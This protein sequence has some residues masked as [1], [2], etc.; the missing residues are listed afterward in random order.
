MKKKK[1]VLTSR[2]NRDCDVELVGKEN[3]TPFIDVET[4][5]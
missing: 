5:A 3:K 4:F 1:K 2:S